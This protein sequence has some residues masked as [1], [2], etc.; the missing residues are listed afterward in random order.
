MKQYIVVSY[1][2]LQGMVYVMG[3]KRYLSAVGWQG[4]QPTFT[5]GIVTTIKLYKRESAAWKTALA[6][7]QASSAAEVVVIELQDFPKIL[8]IFDGKHTK[9]ART[10]AWWEYLGKTHQR[11]YTIGQVTHECEILS[12]GM[13]KN[14]KDF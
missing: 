5:Q 13:V 1:S 8:G 4:S 14:I 11:A 7:A 6:M 12:K 3:K 9:K 2:P 10:K